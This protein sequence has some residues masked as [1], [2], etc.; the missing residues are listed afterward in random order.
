MRRQRGHKL[1]D[2][3]DPIA[4]YNG[5]LPHLNGEEIDPENSRPE[6]VERRGRATPVARHGGPSIK[7]APLEWR[8]PSEV[9]R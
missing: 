2:A 3:H 8:A 1:C 6:P 4:P 9:A 7:I 5:A